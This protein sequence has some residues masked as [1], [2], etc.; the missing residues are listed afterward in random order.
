MTFLNPILA[1]AGL[2]CVAVPIIIHILMRRRRRPIEW[3]AMR[4]LLEA[5]R[6]HKKRLRLEQILL[7]AARCL[8]VALVAL[9]LGRPLLGQAGV[10]GGR[11]AI[12]LYLL[13]DNGLA[14]A[15]VSGT[16]PG[17]GDPTALSRHKAAARALVAQLDAG[18]GDRAG[19][20]AL[21]GP[22]RAMVLPASSNTSAVA[23]LIRSLAPT[24]SPTDLPGG[25]DAV[26]RALEAR[27]EADGGRT[28]VVVLSDFLAGSADIERKLAELGRPPGDGLLLMASEP[29]ASGPTNISVAGLEPLRPVLVAGPRA[30]STQTSVRVVLRRTGPG[31]SEAAATTVR[32]TFQTESGTGL[33]APAGSAQAVVRWSPGQA[34]GSTTVNTDLAGASRA[35]GASVLV[36]TID[37]DGIAGDNAW[38]RPIDIRR[39]LRVGLVAPRRLGVRPTIQQYEPADWFRIALDPS[40]AS[41]A[42]AEIELVEIDPASLDAPRLAGL[43]AAIIAAPDAV[44]EASWRRVRAFAEG[45]G[46]V[47][48]SPPRG[49]TVHTWADAFLRDM[50]LPWTI[51]REARAWPEGGAALSPDRPPVVGSADLLALL[52]AELPELSRPVRVFKALAT[53][54]AAS[55]VAP[56][57]LVMLADGTPLVLASPPGVREQTPGDSAASPRGLVVLMTAA[58]AFDWTDLQAR[59]LVVPLIQEIVRQGVGHA[60]G[61]WSGLAG[62]APAAPART[63][64]LRGLT[65]ESQPASVRTAGD[66]AAEP[67]RHAGLWRA[68]DENGGGRGLVALNADPA[69][70]RCEALPP[71]SV[72]SWLSGAAGGA[73]VRW[74]PAD[75]DVGAGGAPSTLRSALQRDED[76]MRLA[77]PLLMGALAFAVLELALA[78]W[79]SHAV[80]TPAEAPA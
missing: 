19:L 64:E 52:T 30:A 1:F 9:A 77:L 26:R 24:D 65:P 71:A 49:V 47:V 80:M 50:G 42:E 8:V 57:S 13:V 69:G 55:L 3:G 43:D 14:S 32:L 25:I 21:G 2:A 6:Q 4:F 7:L 44:P 31:V 54:G 29:A 35:T 58:L 72:A 39:S 40:G 23:D 28:V 66:R 33:S 20:V 62:S 51:G 59:P 37:A 22:A 73:E 11:G 56:G 38:R 12:T 16:G 75:A 60:R 78:R 79:F 67:M 53:S 10:L 48:V 61:S 45:G 74:L 17:A 46:L 63:V 41:G 5:Y 15:A 34:E 36:A 27:T 70:A 68:V 76:G 18:S